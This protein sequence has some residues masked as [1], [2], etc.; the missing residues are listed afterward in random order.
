MNQMRTMAAGIL[1]ALSVGGMSLAQTAT[2]PAVPPTTPPATPAPVTV[3]KTW[4]DSITFKGDIRYRYESINDDSQ[5][6]AD[7][8]TFTRERERIRARLGLEAK[9]NDNL[10]AGI[11]MSTGQS[12]PVSGN[13][14]IGD[15]F[16]K[17]DFK[18]SLA[19]F[20]YNFFGDN[21]NELHL[22][23]G[24]MNNPF[25]TLP[26]DLVWDGDLTPEGLAIKG[27]LPAGAVT[28]ALNASSFWVQERSKDDNDLMMYGAQPIARIEFMPEVS[29]SL[30]GS[31]YGYQDMEGYDVI[32]WENKNNSYGNSTT[33]GSVSGSTTNKA[34]ATE[35]TPILYFAKLDVWALDT[36]FSFFAQGL[37]NTD[38][39]EYDQGHMFGA[40]V[41]KAKNPKTWELGYSYAELEKDSTVGMFTDSDRWG[42]GTDGSGHKIYGKYQVM[43]N[44][45][46]GATYFLDEKKISDPEKTTDYDRLQLDLVASF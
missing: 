33:K 9:C 15:G 21:P 44:L 39:D 46:L 19:Y 13:Q 8:E 2:A 37:S 41:G 43:K 34:W 31:Y 28:L 18:L 29:L 45:Q 3:P 7:K 14:T 36:P 22:V 17:D 23:G 27:Q 6:D 24:K 5:L 20:D 12:D 10:K 40:S 25:E 16:A 42:G 32:D 38:A 26:D 35:F 1:T 30:G 11:Q 4:A